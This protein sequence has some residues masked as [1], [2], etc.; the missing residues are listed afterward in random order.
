MSASGISFMLHEIPFGMLAILGN[1]TISISLLTILYLLVIFTSLCPPV[2][3]D[4][5]G[6][7][8]L[9]PSTRKWVIIIIWLLFTVGVE[10]EL[11]IILFVL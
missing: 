3:F 2:D 5:F 6:S 9:L 11:R 7:F 10:T 4:F 1:V 8:S